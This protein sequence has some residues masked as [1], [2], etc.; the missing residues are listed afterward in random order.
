MTGTPGGAAMR[1][2]RATRT[3]RM[4]SR[5][6]AVHIVRQAVANHYRLRGLDPRG[7]ERSLED[8]RV[9]L[10]VAVLERRHGDG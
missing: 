8:T 4:P 7:A 10:H 3:P 5:M 6:R 1:P 2:E 9:R